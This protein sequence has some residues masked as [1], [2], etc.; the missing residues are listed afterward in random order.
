M[1][2]M[3]VE[4]MKG[5]RILVVGGGG[6]E[7]AIIWKLHQ[8]PWK[9]IIFCTPG[10]GG[11]AEL[12]T[13]VNIN[14][15]DVTGLVAY[16]KEMKIDLVV[17]GP[18]DSLAAGIVDALEVAEIP[19]FG[20]RRKSAL[21]EISKAWAKK[22]MQRNRIP[23]APFNDFDL[24]SEA[25]NF[26][27]GRHLPYVIKA[28]GLCAGKG[29]YVVEDDHEGQRVLKSLMVDGI[30]G[31][32]GDRIIVEKRLCGPEVSYLVFSDGDSTLPMLPAQDHKPLFKGG[33]NTG[34]M[35]AYTPVPFVDS[36]M[37]EWINKNIMNKAVKSF[38]DEG[39][40]YKGVLYGGLIIPSR[41]S[42]LEFNARFGDPETQ[43]ILFKMKSDLLPILIA[44]INGTLKDIPAIKWKPGV[45]LCVVLAS[46]GYPGKP[47][48]GKLIR[49]LDS[50]KELEDICVFHAGTKVVDGNY[51]TNGGRVMGVTVRGK[52]YEDAIQK[53]Y[54][55][56][57]HVN[58]D[59]MYFRT[60]IA[61]EAVD[62]MKR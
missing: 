3:F 37:E 29:A 5:I 42:V 62:F 4:L 15:S 46:R 51:F 1:K 22:M 43:P 36:E 57:V 39:A 26:L 27:I 45:A 52:D 61:A 44:C 19:V 6:R 49:G 21:I 35:G 47:E 32:S 58:F 14:P 60:D 12:A 28:D 16:A 11:I 56:V 41:P 31:R 54:D 50:L 59:G 10:N 23:T 34:G 18:E 33:P 17:I 40:T 53:A 24:F 25:S 7:H 9:P 38:H 13:C 55:A 2:R 8:S 30:H 20:P 48:K